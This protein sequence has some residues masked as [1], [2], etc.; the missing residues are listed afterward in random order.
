M[1][2]GPVLARRPVHREVPV[3]VP[4]LAGTDGDVHAVIV[5]DQA[6]GVDAVV[7]APL[8]A[9]LALHHQAGLVRVALPLPLRVRHAHRDDVPVAVDVLRDQAVDPVLA[10]QEAA[11]AAPGMV[12]RLQREL[13]AVGVD[14]GDDVER[15]RVDQP[16]HLLVGAVAGQQAVDRV[17]RGRAGGVL[18][19]VD[20]RVDV[21]AGLLLGRAGVGVGDRHEPDVATPVGLGDGGQGGELRIRLGQRLQV[22]GQG[23]VVVIGVEGD[24]GHVAAPWR[25]NRSMMAAA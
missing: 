1:L 16:R 17:E 6:L 25:P 9:R 14:A 18:L 15:L 12:G 19:G 4:V 23:V 13:R 2:P 11:V 7:L 5:A 24:V 8:L 3:H 22:R 20:L 21:E 10:G